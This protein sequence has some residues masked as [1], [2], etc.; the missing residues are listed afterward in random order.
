MFDILF[1]EWNPLIDPAESAALPAR[2]SDLTG[3][4]PPNKNP[5]YGRD[6]CLDL[7]PAPVNSET[8]RVGGPQYWK[9]HRIEAPSP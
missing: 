6:N 4:A 1:H 7:L 5:H 2:V 3:S 8:L 9:G